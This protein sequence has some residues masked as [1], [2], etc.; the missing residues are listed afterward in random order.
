MGSIGTPMPAPPARSW[1]SGATDVGP[2]SRMSRLRSACASMYHWRSWTRSGLRSSVYATN[3]RARARGESTR[4][5]EA[6]VVSAAMV[7]DGS[8]QLSGR[9][10]ISFP[11]R[12]RMRRSDWRKI[13]EPTTTTG[14]LK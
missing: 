13:S 11:A 2:F 8:D 12:W 4:T 3:Q 7:V 10:S 9:S 5:A 6:F 1:S 14:L